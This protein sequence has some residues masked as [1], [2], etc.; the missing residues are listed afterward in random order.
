[1]EMLSKQ[2]CLLVVAFDWSHQGI[3]LGVVML[4]TGS[5]YCGIAVGCRGINL[6]SLFL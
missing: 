6:Q 3:G 4:W 1:M 5:R 2:A